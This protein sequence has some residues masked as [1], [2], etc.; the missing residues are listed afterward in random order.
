VAEVCCSGDTKKSENTPDSFSGK[1]FPQHS[2]QTDADDDGMDRM[3]LTQS[4]KT[5]L[6]MLSDLSLS[7]GLLS[8]VSFRDFEPEP[9]QNRFVRQPDTKQHRSL[10][11]PITQSSQIQQVERPLRGSDAI[12]WPRQEPETCLSRPS[13]SRPPASKQHQSSSSSHRLTFIF[14]LILFFNHQSLST[15]L[16][17]ENLKN[18]NH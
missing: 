3:T 18:Q 13:S 11:Q 4:A 15:D 9:R 6:D 10:Q 7:E 8:D 14:N 17:L 12:N 5:M 1:N 16:L 2:G